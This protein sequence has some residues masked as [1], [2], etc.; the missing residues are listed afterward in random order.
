MLSIY[1]HIPFCLKKCDYC[2]FYSVPIGQTR[3]P[4]AGYFAAIQ[5]QLRKDVACYRL[6]GRNV[7]SIYFGGGTPSVMPPEFF[8]GVIAELE[9]HFSFDGNIEI[10]S[11]VNPATCDKDWFDSVL[12]VGVNRISIGVQSFNLRLLQM[13]GRIHDAQDAMGAIAM[14]QDAGFK[15]VS[16]DLMYAILDES[17]QELENDLR[18][19]MTFQPEH[20]SAYQ[21]TIEEGTPLFCHCEEPRPIRDEATWQ[22]PGDCFAPCRARNDKD[23]GQ[24]KQLRTVSRMLSRGGWQR[25]EISNFAK[26]GFECRH[27]LNYWNYGEYLGLGAGAVSFF[28]VGDGENFAQRISQIKDVKLYLK[29]LSSLRE[30]NAVPSSLVGDP[31]N[32]EKIDQKTAMGEFCFMGL[33]NTC[34]ISPDDFEKIFGIGFDP[35]YKTRCDALIAQGLLEHAKSYYHLTQKGLEISNQVFAELI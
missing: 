8:R 23:L 7:G 2:D 24:L 28:K 21:L 14:T 11:E 19:V 29:T 9:K 10:S 1:I 17:M 22:S 6:E 15:S 33:R 34:G 20:I 18:T 5:T 25:Y 31:F 35:I 4:H 26:R 3:P 27:N 12:D 13:L 16:V 30:K 32:I